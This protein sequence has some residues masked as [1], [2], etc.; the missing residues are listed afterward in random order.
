MISILKA[1]HF[2]SFWNRG[3]GELG[4]GLLNILLIN[5]KEEEE[6]QYSQIILS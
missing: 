2:T 4:N 3:L 5:N 6:N 1:E